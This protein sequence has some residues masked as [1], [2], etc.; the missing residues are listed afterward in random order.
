MLE[1]LNHAWSQ[2][3]SLEAALNNV[4][5]HRYFMYLQSQ[6]GKGVRILEGTNWQETLLWMSLWTD[7]LWRSELMGLGKKEIPWILNRN[8]RFHRDFPVCVHLIVYTKAE[9]TSHPCHLMLAEKTNVYVCLC[10]CVNVYVCLSLY[11][12]ADRYSYEDL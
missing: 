9:H 3:I 1:W 12:D 5:Q 8:L 11:L 6:M 2:C 4:M 10:A 7:A